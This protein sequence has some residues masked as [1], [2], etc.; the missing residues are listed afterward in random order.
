MGLDSLR[1]YFRH[2]GATDTLHLDRNGQE[3]MVTLRQGS[4][5]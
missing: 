4:L 3:R 2:P 1:H 5:P